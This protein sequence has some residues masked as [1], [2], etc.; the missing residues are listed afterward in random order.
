MLNECLTG[1]LS[2]IGG[3][4]ERCFE[5]HAQGPVPFGPTDREGPT[6]HL[7]E[8][9]LG[10]IEVIKRDVKDLK[11]VPFGVAWKEV[12]RALCGSIR[13]PRRGIV[14]L[15]TRIWRAH[16]RAAENLSQH[17]KAKFENCV[18]YMEQARRNAVDALQTRGMPPLD[19]CNMTKICLL[20][21]QFNAGTTF[22]DHSLD[23][24]KGLLSK[25]NVQQALRDAVQ[26]RS[27]NRKHWRPILRECYHM[28][29]RRNGLQRILE[30]S[31]TRAATRGR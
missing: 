30:A 19:Y 17:V 27:A 29:Q 5:R 18:N 11:Y 22:F 4:G 23:Y 15:S 14:R 26:V 12:D 16:A 24:M 10:S 7:R 31:W 8:A 6:W 3:L 9:L 21:A 13:A 25:P 2:S 28:L 1:M 20:H